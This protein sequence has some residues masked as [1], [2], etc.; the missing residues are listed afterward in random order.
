M[1]SYEQTLRLFI[2]YLKH[3]NE[4]Q[5]IKEYFANIKE[6]GK[7]TVFADDNTPKDINDKIIVKYENACDII[8]AI[9]TYEDVSSKM[10]HLIEMQMYIRRVYMTE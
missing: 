10:G 2:R 4:E 3:R 9:A 8:S 7:Y 1:K 5:H 6:S